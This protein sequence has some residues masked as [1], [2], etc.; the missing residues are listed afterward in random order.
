MRVACGLQGVTCVAQQA[1][2]FHPAIELDSAI[3]LIF[4]TDSFALGGMLG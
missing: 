3:Q 1:V 2:E 4:Q